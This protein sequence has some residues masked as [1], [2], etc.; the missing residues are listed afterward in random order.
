[1]HRAQIASRA[2][3]RIVLGRRG[4]FI[5]IAL[6]AAC[7]A[8]VLLAQTASA[9]AR[10]ERSSPGK[11]EVLTSPPASVEI[12]FTQ[13][14][15]KIAGT[16]GIEVNKDRGPD[17]T[18][19]PAVVDDNDRRKL[20]VRLQPGLSPGRYVVRWKNVSDADGDPA[21]GAFSFYIGQGPNA[22]DLENDRQLEQI[23]AEEETPQAT[24]TS[25]TAAATSAATPGTTRPA[26]TA[27]PASAGASGDGDSNTGL[28]VLLGVVAAG[29]VVGG[30]G[31]YF[32][33][34]R[35]P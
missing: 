27:T 7:G 31:G 1:M 21:E 25:A 33:V 32:F 30:T 5:A 26:A 17:A 16:Y 22:V 23:G 3:P 11:G 28:W 35:R 24:G 18:A 4:A 9:H 10:Y 15:Q 20:S 29:I 8:V 13:E 34:R 14:I 6:L 19:G 2:R 12:T